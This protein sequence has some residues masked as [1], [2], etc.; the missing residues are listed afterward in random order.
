MNK[1]KFLLVILSFIVSLLLAGCNEKTNNPSIQ[2]ED[3]FIDAKTDSYQ[4]LDQ[5]E[6]ASDLI[7]IGTKTK[8]LESSVIYDENEGY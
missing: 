3:I 8:E 4:T 6:K 1:N 2:H 5:L 7:V